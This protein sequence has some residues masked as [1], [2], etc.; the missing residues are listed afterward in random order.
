MIRISPDRY[1]DGGLTIVRNPVTLKWECTCGQPECDHIAQAD[2]LEQDWQAAHPDHKPGV[3]PGVW[4]QA[5]VGWPP[6]AL[7]PAFR[8]HCLV[9]LLWLDGNRVILFD[10]QSAAIHSTAKDLEGKVKLM[11][12]HG[13]A[14]PSNRQE[15]L[16][17]RYD[18]CR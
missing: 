2:R 1:I 17:E 8:P 14:L 5:Q 4:Y 13:H 6:I 18:R 10:G 7:P 15:I 16:R 12:P 11:R 9:Y 3:R